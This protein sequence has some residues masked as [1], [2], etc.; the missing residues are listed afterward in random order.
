MFVLNQPF[1][2][3]K[4]LITNILSTLKK[5]MEGYQV[6]KKKETTSLLYLLRKRL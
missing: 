4:V 6:Q 5:T 2:Q 3:Y 1:L